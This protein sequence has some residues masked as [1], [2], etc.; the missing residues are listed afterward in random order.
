MLERVVVEPGKSFV[1]HI[2]VKLDKKTVGLR[3]GFQ[4]FTAPDGTLGPNQQIVQLGPY[5]S[6]RITVTLPD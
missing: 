3:V 6:N 1:G 5:W 2:S 4:S